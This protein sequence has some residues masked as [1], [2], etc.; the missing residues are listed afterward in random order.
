M[1]KSSSSFYPTLLISLLSFFFLSHTESAT[2]S[3]VRIGCCCDFEHDGDKLTWTKSKWCCVHSLGLPQLP[4]SRARL[5]Y[6][7]EACKST[8]HGFRR[9]SATALVITL[10][11]SNVSTESVRHNING[12]FL[13]SEASKEIDAYTKDKSSHYSRQFLPVIGILRVLFL[14]NKNIVI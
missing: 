14:F 7:A 10:N 13:W 4:L 1:L 9:A 3:T 11:L 6:I 12:I 8:P 5:N 2:I